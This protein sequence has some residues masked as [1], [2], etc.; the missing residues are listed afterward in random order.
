[1]GTRVRARYD[2]LAQWCEQYNAPHAEANHDAVVELLGTGSDWCL[3]LGC[4]TGQYIP[5]IRQTGCRVVGLDLSADQLRHAKVRA[6]GALVQADACALP[7][8]PGVFTTATALW[9]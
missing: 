3:D 2:G 5:G 4:G 6:G 7:F 9:I 1:M 8:A